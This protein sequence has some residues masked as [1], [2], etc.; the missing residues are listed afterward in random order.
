MKGKI[1]E[2]FADSIKTREHKGFPLYECRV[3]LIRVKTYRDDI[4]VVT[5]EAGELND[6]GGLKNR[7]EERKLLDS[8]SKFDADLIRQTIVMFDEFVSK[9]K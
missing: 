1:K 6:Y 7:I 2:L 3:K 8:A 9:Q 5:M 4:A